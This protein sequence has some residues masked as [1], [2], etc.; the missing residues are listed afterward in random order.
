MCYVIVYILFLSNVQVISDLAN[1][2]TTGMK[3]GEYQFSI[4]LKMDNLDSGVLHQLRK[5]GNVQVA[6]C[7]QMCLFAHRVL[8]RVLMFDVEINKSNLTAP[9]PK[10]R[11]YDHK[12]GTGKRP[13]SSGSGESENK[14][15]KTGETSTADQPG[16]SEGAGVES[17]SGGKSGSGGE[18]GSG[19]ESR[20][21]AG[22]EIEHMEDE[23]SENASDENANVYVD[24]D[25]KIFCRIWAERKKFTAAFKER[26]YT[27][28]VELEQA[29][30]ER[31]YYD[32][33]GP[34]RY[35]LV[36]YNTIVK[37]IITGSKAT[38]LFEFQGDLKQKE[39]FC[40]YNYIKKFL[41]KLA[42]KHFQ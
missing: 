2:S 5:T 41:T 23:S 26:G 27:D 28:S 24:M 39:F 11:Y 36:E 29:V 35:P 9:L 40:V 32:H 4:D 14:K 3:L 12:K 31:L 18:S 8:E 34:A 6:W 16:T 17:G 19:V 10:S 21:G 7:R 15:S 33:F 37:S 42:D 25:I 22:A 1:V 20:S 38:L 30:S 13:A